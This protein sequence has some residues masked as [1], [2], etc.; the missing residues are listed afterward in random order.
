MKQLSHSS[1]IDDTKPD[2]LSS[3][4]PGFFPCFCSLSI[5]CSWLSHMSDLESSEALQQVALPGRD[6]DTLPA[7]GK[8]LYTPL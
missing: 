5:V 4:A 7:A 1:P 2:A 6:M 3:V 8:R